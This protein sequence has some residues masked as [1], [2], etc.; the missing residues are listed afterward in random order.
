[1]GIH[2]V[3]VPKVPKYLAINIDMLNGWWGDGTGHL[4]TY[5]GYNG[6][7]QDGPKLV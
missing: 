4:I 7:G 3:A 2:A 6:S 1:M 5:T